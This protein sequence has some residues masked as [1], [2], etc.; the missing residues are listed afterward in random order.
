M[1]YRLFVLAT[2]LA[3]AGC[4]HA[5]PHATEAEPTTVDIQGAGEWKR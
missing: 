1:R 4:T 5:P 2:L 3:A